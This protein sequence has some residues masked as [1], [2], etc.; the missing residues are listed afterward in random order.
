MSTSDSEGPLLDIFE[1][2]YSFVLNQSVGSGLVSSTADLWYQYLSNEGSVD[3]D[4]FANLVSQAPETLSGLFEGLLSPAL[5]APALVAVLQCFK[6]Y[7]PSDLPPGEARG[8]WQESIGEA[9]YHALCDE[10]QC[11][12]VTATP[13]PIPLLEALQTVL[14]YLTHSLPPPP[15]TPPMHREGEAEYPPVSVEDMVNAL[16]PEL[17]AV[18]R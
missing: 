6:A 18:I 7:V 15:A 12:R 2:F 10:C 1:G 16:P 11:S 8:L 4:H 5:S 14:F 3:L 13:L 9:E 17:A